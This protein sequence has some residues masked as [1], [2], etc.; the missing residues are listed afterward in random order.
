MKY[1]SKDGG[2]RLVRLRLPVCCPRVLPI[3]LCNVCLPKISTKVEAK[4]VGSFNRWVYLEIQ[5]AAARAREK[6]ATF[7]T[8]YLGTSDDVCYA[9]VWDWKQNS[10]YISVQYKELCQPCMLYNT[11]D[12]MVIYVVIHMWVTHMVY[13][14]AIYIDDT[15][16][17]HTLKWLFR[18]PGVHPPP[19][20][21]S[22]LSNCTSHAHEGRMSV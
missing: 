13:I 21:Y 22:L 6:D 1:E 11:E 19:S 8:S 2:W 10:C 5:R 4:T 14:Y 20:L 3:S 17:I 7:H 16:H 15:L 18:V 12:I 9:H